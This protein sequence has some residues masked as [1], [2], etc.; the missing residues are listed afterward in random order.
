M[1]DLEPITGARGMPG[2]DW[3]SAC[4]LEA[5]LQQGWAQSQLGEH[6]P[7]GA[8]AKFPSVP[9]KLGARLTCP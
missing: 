6:G 2:A 3:L 5:L 4:A 9:S 7:R 8:G 1:L